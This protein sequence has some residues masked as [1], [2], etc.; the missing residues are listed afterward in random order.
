MILRHKQHRLLSKLILFS[1]LI[2]IGL[3]AGIAQNHLSVNASTSDVLEYP[4][5]MSKSNIPTNNQTDEDFASQ[6]NNTENDDATKPIDVNRPIKDIFPDP[7]LAYSVAHSL[8]TVA[9]DPDSP[10]LTVNDR[11]TDSPDFGNDNVQLAIYPIDGQTDNPKNPYL[12]RNWTGMSALKHKLITIKL[13]DQGDNFNKKV[14]PLV[15][16]DSGFFSSNPSNDSMELNFD[17]DGIT[18]GTFDSLMTDLKDVSVN[19][20]YLDSNYIQ[21]FKILNTVKFTGKDPSSDNSNEPF[22]SYFYAA[23]QFG[24]ATVKPSKQLVVSKDGTLILDHTDMREL[25][26][27][28]SESLPGMRYTNMF[29]TTNRLSVYQQ[30]TATDGAKAI[31]RDLIPDNLVYE[32]NVGFPNATNRQ[33]IIDLVNNYMSNTINIAQPAWNPVGAFDSNGTLIYNDEYSQKPATFLSAIDRVVSNLNKTLPQLQTDPIKSTDITAKYNTT[34]V[35]VGNIPQDA[36]SITMRTN[37]MDTSSNGNYYGNT[38]DIPISH[39]SEIS[40]SN[41]ANGG[42]TDTSTPSTPSSEAN[43]VSSTDHQQSTAPAVKKGQAVYAIQKVKLHKAATFSR[44]TTKYTYAKQ[45]RTKRPQF[46]V[47]GYA[48]SKSGLLRYR[49]RDVNHHS[50]SDGKIGYLTSNAKFVVNTYYR[51]NPKKIQVINSKGINAYRNIKLNGKAV[52]HYRRGTTLKIKRIKSHHL[53]TRL[54]LSNGTWITAN[55]TLIIKK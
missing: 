5:D 33:Q 54:Q 47:L 38:I 26:N 35:V 29:D 53:T 39:E 46:V 11:L 18:Q 43:H 50:K 9:T 36:S 27:M 1:A 8:K 23:N 31:P 21:D 20:L 34:G 30:S 51:V 40:S 6:I 3:S 12:I 44:H 28:P 15:Q 19:R 16:K 2:G 24:A 48:H 4:S 7:I 52:K 49:V 37:Y 13:N 32:M 55:K 25:N 42:H 22:H 45:S 17:G 14:L 10:R 41:G